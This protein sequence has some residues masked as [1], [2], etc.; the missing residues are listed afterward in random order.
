MDVEDPSVALVEDNPTDQELR[1]TL[2]IIDYFFTLA[3][4][5]SS[6]VSHDV[7]NLLLFSFYHILVKLFGI[8]TVLPCTCERMVVV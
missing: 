2:V 4:V 1:A 5:R 6:Y 7:R 8:T 3:L